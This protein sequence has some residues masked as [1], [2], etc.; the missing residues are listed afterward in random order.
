MEIPESHATL[1]TRRPTS[2]L[3]TP[4]LFACNWLF[5]NPKPSVPPSQPLTLL[6]YIVIYRLLRITAS[7]I[8]SC[9]SDAWWHFFFLSSSRGLC[10]FTLDVSSPFFRSLPSLATLSTGNY[11][12]HYHVRHT[13]TD[14]SVRIIHVDLTGP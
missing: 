10:V 12:S 4:Y 13:T 9:G 1:P 6:L 11:T 2:L 3:A 7:V 8:A 14:T 5:S